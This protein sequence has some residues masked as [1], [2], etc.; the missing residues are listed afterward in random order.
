M[1]V[2]RTD[3]RLNSACGVEK[4]RFSAFTHTPAAFNFGSRQRLKAAAVMRN[5][6]ATLPRPRNFVLRIPPVCFIHPKGSFGTL[7]ELVQE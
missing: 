2:S 6:Q 5:C 1:V 3:S 7:I 4:R